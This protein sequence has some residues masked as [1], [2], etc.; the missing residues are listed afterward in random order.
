MSLSNSKNIKW[1]YLEEND[2]TSAAGIL[3][4]KNMTRG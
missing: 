1:N 2:L 3:E 4:D